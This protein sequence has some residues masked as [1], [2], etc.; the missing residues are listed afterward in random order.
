LRD[1]LWIEELIKM[2]PAAIIPQEPNPMATRAK[3]SSDCSNRVDDLPMRK[4][5]EMIIRFPSIPHSTGYIFLEDQKSVMRDKTIHGTM[6]MKSSIPTSTS[7][8]K[9]GAPFASLFSLNVTNGS[10]KD[11]IPM[12]IPSTVTL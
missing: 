4:N 10:E 8:E 5:T 9:S 3:A 11:K 2:Y 7:H 12:I 1:S 6:I